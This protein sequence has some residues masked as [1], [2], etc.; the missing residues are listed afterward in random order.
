[1]RSPPILVI[2]IWSG[3]DGARAWQR[4]NQWI[5]GWRE[6][7]AAYDGLLSLRQLERSLIN[8]RRFRG[9]DLLLHEPNLFQ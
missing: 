4:D 3:P 2:P 6:A 8:E 7:I 9:E 1:M 5:V